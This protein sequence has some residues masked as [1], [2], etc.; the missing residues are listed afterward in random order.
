MPAGGTW[1]TQNKRR[2]G[3]YI[4]FKATKKTA[5]S[6]PDRGII[7]VAMPLSWGEEDALTELYATD[8]IDGNS[9]PKIGLTAYDEGSLPFRL[10]LHSCYK[11]LIYN[12]R[13]GGSRATAQITDENTTLT[14]KYPGTMG[15]N[16]TVTT[17]EN[18]PE[19]GKTTVQ[20]LYRNILK[21]TFVV[22]TPEEFTNI[23][24]KYVVFKCSAGSIPASAGTKLS[25]GSDGSET[26][27][28]SNMFKLLSTE[29]WNTIVISDSDGSQES[30]EELYTMVQKF[31]D[32]L[33]KKVQ[34]VAYNEKEFSSGNPV[35][36]FT[37]SEFMLATR[38][39]LV[40]GNDKITKPLF[41]VLAAS[42]TAGAQINE[43][44]T[45]AVLFESGAKVE[46]PVAENKIADALDLGWF[47]LS[48]RQD[49][50]V[51]V[52]Q[53]INTLRTFGD[54][55]N[56][57]FTKNRVIRTLDTIAN[58]VTLVFNKN[59]VGKA[60][61]DDDNR[62]QFKSEIISLMN[63][64]Q[65]MGAVQNFLATTDV[66]VMQGEAIDAVVVD[67]YVQPVDSMEKLYMTVY[68][69]M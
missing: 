31:R 60:S 50:A 18:K 40:V 61:N 63:Q 1:V 11:A 49:G 52:E 65:E 33:G 4:N 14:A 38:D 28:Y 43:S 45:A 19:E 26:E 20:V 64:M 58:Q 32:E 53:D 9:I 5:T 2:P 35:P 23:E 30:V 37:D 21:E 39:S 56:Y 62:N 16:I 68:V 51:C 12:T 48:Y 7:A 41:A 22:S 42:L 6:L 24:S 29:N 66:E 47:L 54:D 10:A 17:I 27:D 3:A 8:L 55:K 15:N 34:G 13:T 44:N 36:P 67:L 59:Y 57:S 69:N 46:D 25:T